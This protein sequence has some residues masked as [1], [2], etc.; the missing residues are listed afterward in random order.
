MPRRPA[1]AE[2][3]AVA[4]HRVR[5]LVEGSAPEDDLSPVRLAKE[6]GFA[7][8]HFHRV[9][10]AYTGSSLAEYV[11]TVR[12][13]RAARAL[14]HSSR[15]VTDIALDSGFEASESFSRSFRR[16]LGTTP[17]TFRAETRLTPEA[18]SVEWRELPP[19]RLIALRHQGPWDGLGASYGRLLAWANATGAP[20][21]RVLGLN[22]DDPDVIPPALLRYDACL[23]CDAAPPEFA[24]IQ[25]LP[26][27]LYAI[28]RHVGPLETLL[29]T[30]LGLLGVWASA[31][32]VRLVDEPVVE[33][34]LTDPLT[35]PPAELVTELW[36]RVHTDDAS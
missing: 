33:L 18:P 1:R 17:S 3:Y 14:R 2:D 34:S 19:R 26:G 28:A 9:F 11:R 6:A 16:T 35:T 22:Y 15:P 29:D 23:E 24:T 36:V 31:T 32:R 21:L 13:Q 12:L 5:A 27:G 8:H 25:V 10:R 4:L 30:Y 20:V 7:L